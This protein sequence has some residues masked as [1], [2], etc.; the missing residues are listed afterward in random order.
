MP[1]AAPLYFWEAFSQTR[2]PP[3]QNEASASLQRPQNPVKGSARVGAH[4]WR[5]RK[6][7]QR[8]MARHRWLAFQRHLR[9]ARGA[10]SA[11]CGGTYGSIQSEGSVR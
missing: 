6:M 7:R 5:K 8:T 11:C 1:S 10:E 2:A 4:T 9:F 3:T